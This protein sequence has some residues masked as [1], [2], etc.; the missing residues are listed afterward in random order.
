MWNVI[1][2]LI[3]YYLSSVIGEGR[4]MVTYDI[5]GLI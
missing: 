1:A 4:L 3:C 2:G 5:T